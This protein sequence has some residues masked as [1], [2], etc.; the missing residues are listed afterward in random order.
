[1]NELSIAPAVDT[2]IMAQDEI[3]ALREQ[4]ESN[5]LELGKRL[6]DFIERGL[7]G[8]NGLKHR[9]INE[10]L[11]SRSLGIGRAMGWQLIQV[12]RTFGESK[13]LDSDRLARAGHAKLYIASTQIGKHSDIPD[14][15]AAVEFAVEYSARELKRKFQATRDIE[16]KV[17]CPTCGRTVK[18][19]QATWA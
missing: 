4:T 18:E 9:T 15:E 7:W 19:S 3:I 10:W 8:D 6:D 16:P 2:A 17:E 5:F 12:W 11:D 13:R 1:M 14:V